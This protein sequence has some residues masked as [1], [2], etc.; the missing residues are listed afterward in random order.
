MIFD[1]FDNI[2]GNQITVAP[3][4][5][6]E[7]EPVTSLDNFIAQREERVKKSD[8]LHFYDLYQIHIN[9]TYITG[10]NAHKVSKTMLGK[11]QFFANSLKKKKKRSANYLLLLTDKKERSIEGNESGLEEDDLSIQEIKGSISRTS[12]DSS[13]LERNINDPISIKSEGEPTVE[14][15]A[16]IQQKTQVCDDPHLIGINKAGFRSLNWSMKALN[17]KAL[18]KKAK[19]ANQIYGMCLE[20]DERIQ[21]ESFVS[22]DEIVKKPKPLRAEDELCSICTKNYVLKDFIAKLC[23]CNHVFHKKCIDSWIK[24]SNPEDLRCP[25]CR[26]SI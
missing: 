6:H 10:Q 16:S 4:S 11:R 26:S 23:S 3:N 13:V 2:S 7:L 17:F 18:W 1:D 22:L 24:Q 14:N 25:L 9:K 19:S 20:E 8:Y 5:Q 15:E 21:L 12:S